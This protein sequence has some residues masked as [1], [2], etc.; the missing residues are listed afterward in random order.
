MKWWLSI[1]GHCIDLSSFNTAMAIFSA[2][3]NSAVFRLR[4]T[5]AE[6]G[7]K[8]MREYERLTN[9]FQPDENFRA[10]RILMKETSP[11]CIPY[12]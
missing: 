11:P 8:G 5:W 6:I 3:N 4:K 12:L 9:I 1:A 2:L 10:M 7:K